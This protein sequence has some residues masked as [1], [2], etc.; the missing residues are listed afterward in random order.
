MT[1]KG[2]PIE[3]DE[4]A[5]W[6]ETVLFRRDER[7]CAWNIYSD[8]RPRV[9]PSETNQ[10]KLRYT[11][12][13]TNLARG[14]KGRC[15]WSRRGTRHDDQ[16][17]FKWNSQNEPAAFASARIRIGGER[18]RSHTLCIRP[19]YVARRLVPALYLPDNLTPIY[20]FV[21]VK[22]LASPK[23]YHGRIIETLKLVDSQKNSIC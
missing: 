6:D 19:F 3:G 15:G 2:V 18:P 21:R 1:N 17:L 23:K 10:W 22:S 11:V 9:S 4:V 7:K 12:G 20:G 5:V 8:I 16:E 13:K 14:S